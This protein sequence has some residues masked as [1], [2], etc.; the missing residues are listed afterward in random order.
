MPTAPLFYQPLVLARVQSAKIADT[1]VVDSFNQQQKLINEAYSNPKFRPAIDGLV[2]GF[3]KLQE[4][5]PGSRTLEKPQFSFDENGYIANRVMTT[6]RL[7]PNLFDSASP[8]Q[9]AEIGAKLVEEAKKELGENPGMRA[10]GDTLEVAPDVTRLLQKHWEGGEL[11]A[12]D[13][14]YLGVTATRELH[15][16]VTPLEPD[17]THPQLQWIEDG[18]AWMLGMWPGAVSKTAAALG[19]KADGKEVEKIVDAWRKD[20]QSVEPKV[21]GP[22]A[23]LT[24]IL[25]AAGISGS[26]EA[27]GAA[28]YQVLQGSPLEGVPVGIAQALVGHNKLPVDK[29]E[30]LASRIVETTGS[31]GNVA[32]LIA[33]IELMKQPPPVEPPPGG[34]PPPP[35]G[36]TPPPGPPNPEPPPGGTTP[37]PVEPPQPVPAK[38]DPA[39]PDPAKPDPAVPGEGEQQV[40][41]VT[42]GG[43][44]PMSQE[45]F[46]KLLAEVQAEIDAEQ[47]PHPVNAEAAAADHGHAH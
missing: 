36:G 30:Y 11:S 24:A 43:Q 31:P 44:T 4:G 35:G 19:L 42:G 9:A 20:M 22:L 41:T 12:G 23:S 2:N 32:G 13:A 45:E 5:M 27:A 3:T 28:A 10:V 39:K 26:D 38:P 16:A 40:A 47:G 33:E 21:V 46:D 1:T 34:P 25:N 15:R 18:T 29:A 7:H 14:A 8:D 37:P 6:M 17:A